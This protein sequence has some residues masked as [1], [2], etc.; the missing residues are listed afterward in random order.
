MKEEDLGWFISEGFDVYLYLDSGQES[1]SDDNKD[2]NLCLHMSAYKE[3]RMCG[4][5]A[6]I[7]DKK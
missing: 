5:P 2:D 3:R 7:T 6:Y 4:V 1:L